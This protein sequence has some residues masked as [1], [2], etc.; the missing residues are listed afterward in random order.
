M[1]RKFPLPIEQGGAHF[2]DRGDDR[3]G[4]RDLFGQEGGI[5]EGSWVDPP[6]RGCRC[7]RIGRI[8]ASSEH[9]MG[10]GAVKLAG[11]EMGK[12]E[13]LG[14]AARQRPLARGGR[15][16]DRDDERGGGP[17]IATGASSTS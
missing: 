10:G 7:L 2:R 15:P 1:C 5:G 17:S 3:G 11:V 13:T 12:A 6:C 14:E 16:V 8:R 4:L 9:E